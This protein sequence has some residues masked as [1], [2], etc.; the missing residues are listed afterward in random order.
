MSVTNDDYDFD[1]LCEMAEIVKNMPECDRKLIRPYV[2]SAW[3]NLEKNYLTK[4]N[5]TEKPSL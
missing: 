5:L 2:R 4:E 3:L 1:K